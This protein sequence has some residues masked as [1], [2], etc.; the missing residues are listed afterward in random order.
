MAATGQRPAAQVPSYTSP[1]A[2]VIARRQNEQDALRLLFVLRK[3]YS[4]SK[5]F[6]AFRMWGMG[7]IAIAAPI[8][9]FIW[10]GTQVAVGAVAG[11]WLVLGRIY[12]IVMEKRYT[13]QAAAVQE[14]FDVYVFKMPEIAMRPQ[15]PS[16]EEIASIAGPDSE[17]QAK[18]AKENLLDWYPIDVQDSGVTAVAVS[19]RANASYSQSL[20]KVTSRLWVWLILGWT[21]IL[22]IISIMLGL[23]LATFLLAVF[24][25]L[26]SPVIELF[27][28]WKGIRI[29]SA[30]RGSMS[31]EIEDKLKNGGVTGEELVIWQARMYDLRVAMPQVPNM[32]YKLQRKANER[33]MKTAAKQLSDRR[34]RP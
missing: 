34:R 27:E 3:L 9:A 21:A 5:K 23:S 16:L 14:L 15:T 13:R 30:E 28:Y 32:L 19:Q 2:R 26:A 4:K 1:S 17:L 31:Q 33:A 6:L 29:A 18:A 22:I 24:L 12:F 8:I 11:A 25:P 20:L 10:P 7:A